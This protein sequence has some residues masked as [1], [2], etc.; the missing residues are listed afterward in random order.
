MIID[1]YKWS[2]KYTTNSKIYI[3]ITNYKWG[4]VYSVNTCICRVAFIINMNFDKFN[5]IEN[6]ILVIED[7]L[8]DVVDQL[9]PAYF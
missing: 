7:V 8:L 9:S 4:C 5:L 3:F 2:H 6:A 1:K